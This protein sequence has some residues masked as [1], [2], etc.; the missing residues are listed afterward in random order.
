M[1]QQLAAVYSLP[2]KCIIWN[3]ILFIPAN[4]RRHEIVY[5]A[6]PAD[7]GQGC[8]IS[9]HIRQPEYSAFRS[10]L[11]FKILLSFQELTDQALSA[12]QITVRLHPHASF[13][14]PPSEVR[15]LFNFLNVK[16]KMRDFLSDKILW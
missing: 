14:F 16:S 6:F 13:R 5:P 12:G 10:K 15:I 2:Q 8:R 4:L 11:L 9:K 1:G 7:L 3:L